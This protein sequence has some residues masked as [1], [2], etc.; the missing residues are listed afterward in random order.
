M[1]NAIDILFYHLQLFE[2]SGILQQV[3]IH[4]LHT[5]TIRVIFTNEYENKNKLLVASG[6]S[7]WIA[8]TP[9]LFRVSQDFLG[10][11]NLFVL[12]NI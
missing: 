6:N 3:K 7:N 2:K 9:F 4:V 11:G 10:L 8:D 12:D 5:L 1:Y